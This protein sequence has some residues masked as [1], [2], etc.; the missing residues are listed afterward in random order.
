VLD[1]VSIDLRIDIT[2]HALGVDLEA[3]MQRTRL[4][5]HN[6]RGHRHR[7]GKRTSGQRGFVAQLSFSALGILHKQSRET[8]RVCWIIVQ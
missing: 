8:S 5:A 1:E 3:G 6:P 2:D 4:R 7:G